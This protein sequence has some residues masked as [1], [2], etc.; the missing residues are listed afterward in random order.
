[1]L[2]GRG[3]RYEL[4][5][6]PGESYRLWCVVVC[7]LE[8]SK[9]G[10]PYIYIYIYNISTLRVKNEALIVY[11]RPHPIV[12]LHMLSKIKKTSV[13]SMSISRMAFETSK[14]QAGM[15]IITHYIS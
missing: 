12:F 4:I 8:T 13:L 15:L 5:T 9:V 2:S 14:I 11:F 7:D 1:M 6:R 3:L 10:A